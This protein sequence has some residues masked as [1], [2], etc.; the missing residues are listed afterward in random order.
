MQYQNLLNFY[1]TLNK[2]LHLKGKYK[3][4]LRI[5]KKSILFAR[6][7]IYTL[8]RINKNEF[9][10]ENNLITLRPNSGIGAE[11]W[12]K[13]IGKKSKFGLKKGIPLKFNYID[14]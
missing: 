12:D 8:R 3:K 9:F 10:T 13:V 6:R 14:N 5:E 1:D 2:V 11:N 4:N 7:G